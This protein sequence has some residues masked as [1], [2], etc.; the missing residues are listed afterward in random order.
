MP[1]EGRTAWKTEKWKPLDGAPPRTP[2]WASA[3]MGNHSTRRCY[4]PLTRTAWHLASPCCGTFG[5]T[6]GDILVQYAGD[7][8]LV[9][10]AFLERPHLNVA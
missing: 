3:S 7:K 9:R 6:A 1:V 5:E 2:G 10:D 8:R 4:A